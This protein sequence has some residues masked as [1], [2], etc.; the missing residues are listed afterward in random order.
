MQTNHHQI[1]ILGA[2][3][4]GML[5]AIRLARRTRRH[6]V[7]IVLVN[8]VDRFTERLRLHQLA[9]GQ[10]LPGH[11]ITDLLAGTG[12]TFVRGTATTI[13]TAGR[14][15]TVDSVGPL[16]Y[17]TLVYA[18]GSKADTGIVPGADRYAY[19]LD[20]P[21]TAYRFSARLADLSA[22]GGG[23]VAVCGGGLTGVEAA[24]EIAESHPALRVIL[25]S[26][27]V[28][29]SMMGDRART[30]LH[31]ALARLGVTCRTGVTVARVL[32][33]AVE[34]DGGGRVDA[35]VCLWTAGVRVSP[36]AAEAGIETDPGGLVVVDDALRSVSHPQVYAV[37]DAAAIRQPWGR[38]HGTCQSGVPSAA[39]AADTIARRLR[40]R[41]GRPFRFGYV[42]QPVSLGRRNAVIQFTHAD[43]TPRRW[44]LAGR[45]AAAYKELVNCSP[46]RLY[47]LSRRVN[48][49]LALTRGGRTA[50]TGGAAVRM[51]R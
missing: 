23:T 50:R 13:D 33:D 6:P 39:H 41:P 46:L 1:V 18:L 9:A 40:G 36:L 25:L 47:R 31:R 2:G 27:D 43:D 7:Q 51:D 48:V 38:V 28:P 19:T 26:R 4:T 10:A 34:L 11:R 5:C 8:P 29:G 16:R 49:S 12:V 45:P 17:D 14:Q 42:H 44:Y 32:P 24:A 37:G 21:G 35:D 3:Y 20:D 22:A 30:H 15:V